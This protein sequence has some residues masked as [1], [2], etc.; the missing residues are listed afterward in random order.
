V[1]SRATTSA[2][3]SATG[4][5]T[6]KI[7][8]LGDSTAFGTGASR[9]EDSTAGR[10]GLKYPDAEVVNLAKNGMRI[11]GL[12][13]VL[14]T[15]DAKDVSK[16]DKNKHFDLIL[17]QIGA[18][19]IIRLTPAQDIESGIDKILAKAKSL[20]DKVIVLHSGNVGE[21]KFFPWYIRPILSHRSVN[22]REI[23]IKIAEKHKAEYVDLINAPI[24][25]KL[26]E[27]PSLYY[28]SDLLHLSSEGYGLWYEE[29]RKRL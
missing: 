27:N 13:E 7:L 19:D 18:N 11:A 8:V 14:K 9:P 2:T 5:A 26:R 25:V 24:A 3:T 12:E 4:D 20:G 22:M 6:K 29:I 15:L 17:I 28:S 23:Y 16:Q 21:S 10:L 1:F